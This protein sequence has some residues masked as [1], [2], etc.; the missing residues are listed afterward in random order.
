MAVG[1]YGNTK[2]A[3]VDFSDV[4]I[5]YSFSPSRETIG[6]T[7]LQPLFSSI[8]DADLKK[9]IGADGLFKLRLPATVFNQIGFYTV[10]VKP[11]T[12]ET[13]IQDCSFIVQANNT[14]VTISKK[15][16]IIPA[17][18][19]QK[20]GSLVGFMVEYFDK[21]DIK[22]KNFHRI[23][24]SANLVS[25]STNNNTI[26]RGSA[27]YVLDPN[28]TQ[29]FLTLSPDEPDLISNNTPINLGVKGQNIL[30]SNTTLNPTVIEVE[31]TDETVKT[32]GIILGGN[33]TRDNSTGILTYFTSD[34]LVYKQ[35]NL[36]TRKSQFS[37]ASIDI[38]EQRTIINPQT[39]FSQ[40]SQ[41]LTT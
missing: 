23:I 25:V 20:I 17:T 5:L 13:T 41:G 38:R 31:V 35:Y 33:S 10:V 3:D 21:N 1:I 30:L 14:N 6:D 24:T 37:N 40:A 27:N 16:I 2:L 7:A 39:N 26:S 22:I 36:F 18:Q 28:G 11:K 12:F 4:D 32:L 8:T 34:N 19:F 9:M 29:L 15:G